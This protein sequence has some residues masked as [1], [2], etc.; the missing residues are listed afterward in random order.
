MELFLIYILIAT[1]AYWIWRKRKKRKEQKEAAAFI[2][3]RL[4]EIQ[5]AV[6]E[7]SQLLSLTKGYFP[8]Y[9]LQQWQNKHAGIHELLM[10]LPEDTS[11]IKEEE[12]DSIMTIRSY[13][14]DGES[15]RSKFNSYFIAEELKTYKTFFSNIEN[16]K[17]DLQ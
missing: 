17:L 5:S 1:V 4:P 13:L 2:R 7:F 15:L 9:Q 16:R 6:S 12:I 8:N 11:L 10:A 3:S 14:Q